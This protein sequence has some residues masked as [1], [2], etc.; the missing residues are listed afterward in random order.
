V[1]AD[2]ADRLVHFSRELFPHTFEEYLQALL[3]ED[4]LLYDD[5]WVGNGSPHRQAIL[6]AFGA[7][8]MGVLAER[9]IH[10]DHSNLNDTEDT[11]STRR[12]SVRLRSFLVD[13]DGYVRLSYRTE[14]DF[15]HFLL[16]PQS[17]GSFVGEIPPMPA[18]TVVHY[19]LAAARLDPILV[20][21]L[22]AGAPTE[23]FAYR[24]GPD[25]EPPRIEHGAVRS[26]PA[27]AWPLELSA[28][29]EDNVGVAE[30]NV[31]VWRNGEF[32]GTVGLV[33]E[34]QDPGVWVTRFPNVGGF[35]GD[36]IEY[37]ITAVDASQAAHVTRF[38]AAGRVSLPLVEDLEED[39]ESASSS[40]QHRAV[41]LAH[42]DAWH[43][44]QAFNHG[45]QGQQAWLCGAPEGEY[46]VMTAAELRTDWYRIEPG[47]QA[48]VWSWIDA[49]T[50]PDGTARDGGRIEIQVDGESTWAL[51]TPLQGYTHVVSAAALEN[52]LRPG[53]AC[54]S[55]R[56]EGWR[57]LDLDLEA[58]RGRRVR[59]RFL[60]GSDSQATQE[61]LR[62]WLL[63]DFTLTGGT[64]LDPTDSQE[65]LP[66]RLQVRASPNPFNPRLTFDVQVPLHAGQVRLDI[67]DA[68]GRLHRRL[69]DGLLPAGSHR[70]L[71]DGKD[72]TGL[73]SASGVYYYRLTSAIGQERGSVVL[74]R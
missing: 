26:L 30:A 70:I 71:W 27:F 49:E 54:L 39:F 52:V 74:L 19:Y 8:G 13:E 55:G 16:E 40:W 5:G 24:V 65:S 28:R 35:V 64:G 51:L 31:Q 2:V 36:V 22:P 42:P 37:V 43:L 32:L 44:T 45:A 69:V 56:D 68:R 3:L 21:R 33:P 63:D 53:D 10:I 41:V 9:K 58:W 6:T 14:G 17:D 7:H 23:T 50:S 4:D 73:A 1:G 18:G 47:A 59:L 20:D 57:R 11:E 46:P 38:P 29:I 15:T 61:G 12:V 34:A 25:E 67:L 62:G 72:A 48:S 66:R 60:F